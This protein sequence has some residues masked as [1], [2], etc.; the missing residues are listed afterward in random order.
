MLELL[1]VVEAVGR[2]VVRKRLEREERKIVAAM[3][4]ASIFR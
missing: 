2:A 3:V 1:S 4:V